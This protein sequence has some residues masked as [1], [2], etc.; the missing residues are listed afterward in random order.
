MLVSVKYI[1]L[2]VEAGAATGWFSEG[3]RT[4]SLIGSNEE[5]FHA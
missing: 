3:D 5:Y 4:A 2:Y 1:I